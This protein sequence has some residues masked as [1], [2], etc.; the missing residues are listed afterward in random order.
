MPGNYTGFFVFVFCFLQVCNVGI[1]KLEILPNEE[2]E[3]GRIE[4]AQKKKPTLQADTC[5]ICSCMLAT[6][7]PSCGGDGASSALAYR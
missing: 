1:C 4:I 5:E 3:R 7:G 2:T 6:K